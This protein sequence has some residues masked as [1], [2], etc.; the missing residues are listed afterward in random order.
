MDNSSIVKQMPVSI[1]AEQA[2][3]GSLIINPESFDKV[4]GFITANDFY[5]DEHKHI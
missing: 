2:L 5:L 3:L 1:E 4:A